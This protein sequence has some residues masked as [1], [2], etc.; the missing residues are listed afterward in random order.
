MVENHK[1]TIFQNHEEA[2]AIKQHKKRRM[3]NKEQGNDQ[4]HEYVHEGLLHRNAMEE[5]N[6]N[7]QLTGYQIQQYIQ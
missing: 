7:K 2:E 6:N 3:D 4:V 1:D 5:N